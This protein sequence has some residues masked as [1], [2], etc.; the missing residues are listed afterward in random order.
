MD[1]RFWDLVVVQ[2]SY[3][4]T[5]D[6]YRAVDWFPRAERFRATD[7]LCR[8]ALSVPLNIAEGEGRYSRPDQMHFLHVA[9]GSR[10]EVDLL[11]RLSADMG[12]LDRR[13]YDEL[14]W[15]YDEVG[16]LLNGLIRAKRAM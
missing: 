15:R 1:S 11:L 10:N 8:A 14:I 9:R 5:L 12:W 13:I 16:R 2:K 7:Q 3:G 6:I 4:L